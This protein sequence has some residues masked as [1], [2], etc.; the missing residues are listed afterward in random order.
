MLRKIN[1][2]KLSEIDIITQFILPAIKY[3]GWLVTKAKELLGSCVQL[4]LTYALVEQ[5]I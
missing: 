1:K 2:D 3:A 4:K 5:A